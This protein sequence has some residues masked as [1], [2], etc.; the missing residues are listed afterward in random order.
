MRFEQTTFTS[1]VTLDYNEFVDCTFRD[2]GILFY[3]GRFSLIRAT[4]QNVRFGFG[5]AANNTLA[6]MRLIRSTTN[7][8]ELLRDLLA[9]GPAPPGSV[10]IN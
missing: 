5:D 1:D 3:G 6:F 8:D 10:T 7:G 2:C 4:F 9:A